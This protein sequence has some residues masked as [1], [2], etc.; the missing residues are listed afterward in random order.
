MKNE[1]R[2]LRSAVRSRDVIFHVSD[3]FDV[4]GLGFEYQVLF[5]LVGLFMSF[6]FM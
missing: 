6:I 3:V 4:F 5:V 2:G 1:R